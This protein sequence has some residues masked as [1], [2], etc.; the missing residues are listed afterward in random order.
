ME[1]DSHEFLVPN[2]IA[3]TCSETHQSSEIAHFA[4]IVDGLNSIFDAWKGS[5]YVSL[6]IAKLS[7][8]GAK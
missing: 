4:K 7:N 1:R 5:E 2:K 6:V 8:F 3:E